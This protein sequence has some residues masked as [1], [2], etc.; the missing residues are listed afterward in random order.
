MPPLLD[1]AVVAAGGAV[2][3]MLRYALAIA[4]VRW[5]G[6]T[7]I[8]GTL[9]ANLVGCFAIGTLIAAVVA[10]PEWISARTA[11]GIRVGLLGG[12][13]TFSTFAAE[14]IGLAGESKSAWMFAY[15]IASVVLGMIA[16][17]LGMAIFTRSPAGGS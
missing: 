7:A 15:V 9:V 3:S 14:S 1:F 17:W 13:T 11:L 10:H 8:A 2:G 6:G 12:L 4:S 16:V 5:F